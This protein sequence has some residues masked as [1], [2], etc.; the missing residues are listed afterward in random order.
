MDASFHKSYS[1]FILVSNGTSGT[2]LTLVKKLLAIGYNVAIFGS[3]AYNVE[4]LIKETLD[5]KERIFAKCV[6]ITN[7]KELFI[8]YNEC[9]MLFGKA[10]VLINNFDCIVSS[11]SIDKIS[12]SEIYESINSNL[13]GH[14]YLTTI[15]VKEMQ[16]S[17]NVRQGIVININPSKEIGT[18]NSSL[19]NTSIAGLNAFISIL[20]KDHNIR[21]MSFDSEYANVKS[22]LSEAETPLLAI[23]KLFNLHTKEVIWSRNKREDTIVDAIVYLCE[24]SSSKL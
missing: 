15:V 17:N 18:L 5:T 14:I 20:S 23:Y 21:T 16:Y 9:K 12:S 24:A 13:V 10:F 4:S 1:G 22:Q 11:Q 6:D 8:F 2:S 3:C 7:Y 19:S